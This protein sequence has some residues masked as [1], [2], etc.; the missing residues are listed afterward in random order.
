MC[1]C[2]CACAHTHPHSDIHTLSLYLEQGVP[3]MAVLAVWTTKLLLKPGP[4]AR[5]ALW[6]E[7]V[8]SGVPL[9][10]VFNPLC[11]ALI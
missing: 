6:W 5:D 7:R 10:R 8:A 11:R 2:E 9:S 1:A 4:D 3:R